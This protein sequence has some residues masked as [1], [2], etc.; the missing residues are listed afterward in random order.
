M[1]KVTVTYSK[2]KVV[3]PLSFWVHK[4][5]DA[6]VWQAAT[7]YDPPM[8]VPVLGRGYPQYQIEYRGHLLF[9]SSKEEITHCIDV[10]SQKL[11][12]A[13]RELAHR[14]GY[15]DYQHLHWLAKWPGD[16]KSWGERQQII[17][18]LRRLLRQAA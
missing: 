10:L 9:F 6:A 2:E 5:V 12:P 7:T 13:T 15:P 16:L 17:K 3:S 1:A 8:P 4:A 14:A 18:L 11:L